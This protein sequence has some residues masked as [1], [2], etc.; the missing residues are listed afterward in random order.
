M[1]NILYTIILSLL[2]SSSA[3]AEWTKVNTN[4]RGDIYYVDFERIRKHDGYVYYWTLADYS[5]PSPYG[6]LSSKVYEQ[7]DC[8]LFRSKYISSSYY[9]QPMGKGMPS[10][11]RNTPDKDWN[12]PPPKSAHENIL[13]SVCSW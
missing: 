1:K 8:K 5:K 11:T 6:D 10:I 9:T 7:V 2:F 13:N 12:Y 4:V 3:F